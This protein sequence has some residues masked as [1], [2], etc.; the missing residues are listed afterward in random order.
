MRS[1]RKAPRTSIVALAVAG[2]HLRLVTRCI[3]G[4]CGRNRFEQESPEKRKTNGNPLTQPTS[5][6]TP[7]PPDSGKDSEPSLAFDDAPLVEE[8][9]KGNMRAFGSLVA[10][11]QDRLFNAVLRM[12]GD[13][14]EA[15]DLC[16]EAFLRAL[17]KISEFRGR[18]Q[19]YTWLF[20]I[21]VNLTISQR[22]KG[23][24]VK[25]VSLSPDPQ[26]DDNQAA[27]LTSDVAARREGD[28]ATVAMNRDSCRRVLEA[29]EAMDEEFRAVIVLRDIEDMDYEQMANTLS[30]PVGTIKS[31]LHRA[32]CMLKEK[33]SGMIGQGSKP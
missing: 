15:S 33:L 26:L 9:R 29:L 5:K 4:G 8:S 10:R 3:L 28:P 1:D 32:R 30:L 31:R 25:F 19:F 11:Y 22:R 7:V 17:R 14:E 2:Y 6:L 27:G 21:A 24:R 18:S 12:C 16:Q 20:R 13:R 23:G